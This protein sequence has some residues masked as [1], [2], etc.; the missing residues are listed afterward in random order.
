MHQQLHSTYLDSTHCADG[1]ARHE[2]HAYQMVCHYT[3]LIESDSFQLV[4]AATDRDRQTDRDGET[5][6]DTQ[7]DRDRDRRTH[8]QTETDGRT[9]RQ[10][11][12]ETET[13]RRTYRQRQTGTQTDRDRQ[14]LEK[15][16]VSQ[17]K[18]EPRLF[19]CT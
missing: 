8:R 18:L 16:Q 1:R 5:E 19:T 10:T 14:K 15:F 2:S 11:G 4:L 12:T 6:T 3:V 13:D 7:T 17:Y 9:D